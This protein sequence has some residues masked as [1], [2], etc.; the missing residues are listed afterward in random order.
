MLLACLLYSSFL[1]LEEA[2][3][4][5]SLLS[6]LLYPLALMAVQVAMEVAHIDIFFFR[7]FTLKI[8][9]LKDDLYTFQPTS[10]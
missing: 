3:I 9:L 10:V 8:E 7:L 1:N 5:Q 2:L 4:K 6:K